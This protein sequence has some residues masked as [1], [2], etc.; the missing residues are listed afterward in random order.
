MTA[1]A[2]A[3]ARVLRQFEP[4]ADPGVGAPRAAEAPRP[5]LRVVRAPA[6]GRSRVPFVALCV[7]I[8]AGALVTAL[9]LNIQMAR[10]SFERNTLNAQVSQTAQGVQ[11]LTSKLD[12]ASAP[13]ALAR[14]ARSLGMVPSTG[15]GFLRLSDGKVIATPE[16]AGAKG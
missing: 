2:G 12:A 16:A 11:D 8:V 1:S 13:G 10:D 4:A 15:Q 6:T 9:L 3:P 7:A 14:T 5:R